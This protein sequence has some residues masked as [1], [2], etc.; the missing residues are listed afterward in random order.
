MTESANPAIEKAICQDA[1]T[2]FEIPTTDLERAT[3][4]YEF[5]LNDSLRRENFGEPMH[6]FPAAVTAVGGSLVHRDSQKPSACGTIIYLNCRTGLAA[7]IER[8]EAGK[9]G[10]VIIP[11]TKIPG[12]LGHFAVIRDSEGNH[13]GLHEH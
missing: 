11:I 4:F 10:K 5:L 7:A 8:M 9:R 12:G 3:L 1:A 6:L 2:W 13:V